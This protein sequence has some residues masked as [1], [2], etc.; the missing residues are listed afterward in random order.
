M[1]RGIHLVPAL[2]DKGIRTLV[3]GPESFTPDGLPILDQAR[4]V[5][6]YF[7]LAGL[8][9]SGILRSAGLSLAVAEWIVNGDPGIDVSRFSLSR[10]R[11]EHNDEVWLRDRIRQAPS[12]HFST[13]DG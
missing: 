3:N 8:N 1:E 11:P 12:G 2:A 13:Q 4:S 9:S 10:F 5:N 7:V 6:G